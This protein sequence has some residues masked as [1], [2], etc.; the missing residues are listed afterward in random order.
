ML[1]FIDQLDEEQAANAEKVAKAAKRAGVDPTLAVAIA[2]QESRLRSNPPRGSSGEI[3][4]MQVMPATGKGMGYNEKQLSNLDENIEA[5]VR[6]LKKGL[7]ATGNDPQLAAIYYNGGPGAVQAMTQGK[8]PDPRVFDYLR[9]VNS[10]GTFGPKEGGLDSR[11]VVVE[12]TEEGEPQN[13]QPPGETDEQRDA[14]IAADMQ[15]VQEEQE[16][17]MG[18]IGGAGTGAAVSAYR[19][20]KSGAKSAATALG[21]ASEAGRIAAQTRAG[22]PPGGM[23]PAGAPGAPAAPQS[24]VRVP[25]GAPGGGGL[26]STQLGTPGT[27]PTATGPGS[28]TFNYGRVY[29]LPE[30]EAGRALGTGKAEG[31]VWDLLNKR[32]Q[33]LTNIQQRFP[34]D[35]FIENPRYGGLMTPAPSA[36]GGPRASYVAQPT[37]RDVPP[38]TMF[39]EPPPPAGTM[40][41]LP[42]RQPVPTAPPQ[43]S[44]LQAVTQELKS[45][46]RPVISGAATAGRY[47]VPPLALAGAGGEAADVYSELRKDQPDYIR[48]GLSGLTG[49][50][51]MAAL[52]PPL[53]IPA[54]VVGGSAAL[55]NYLREKQKEQ[56][57]QPAA[58]SVD[59][60]AP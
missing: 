37:M 52:F 16:R 27:Y 32:Q 17:R 55:I 36:G 57:G 31:E 29:G 24:V 38:G 22:L 35:T 5:G 33:A 49:L 20:G 3:G 26:P 41:Q 15:R 42:P 11:G 14:R 19:M 23:P 45:L 25:G 53:T 4:M 28:A 12:T 18:Q 1:N 21:E 7:E 39:V 30:I 47:I 44:G 13:D 43:P 60:A 50:S 58:P 2:F 9:S 56:G 46:A 48:A 54:T 40:R 10:Y 6:F 34:G 59:Y 51:G 8:E